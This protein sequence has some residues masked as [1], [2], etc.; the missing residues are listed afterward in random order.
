MTATYRRLVAFER[1]HHEE[2]L[3]GFSAKQKNGI[4]VTSQKRQR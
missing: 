1:D 3:R 4:M 2:P